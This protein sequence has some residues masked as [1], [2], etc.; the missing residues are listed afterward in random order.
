MAIRVFEVGRYFNLIMT[1]PNDEYLGKMSNV[2]KRVIS[3]DLR[4]FFVA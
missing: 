1:G 3:L 2:Q 4:V